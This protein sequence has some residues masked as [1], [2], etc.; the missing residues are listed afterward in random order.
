[1]LSGAT[2]TARNGGTVRYTGTDMRSAMQAAVNSLTAGRTSKQR[3]VVRGSG[4]VSANS[5]LSLPSYTVLDVCGT[6]NVTGS[7]S[8]D[9]GAGVRP[10][11][12]RCR[13][14]APQPDRDSVVR[15]FHA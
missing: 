8:G 1:M 4:S 10:G 3:V 6:I 12:D 9:R 5:R 2:W 14:A 11:R 15:N 13:G 7:G